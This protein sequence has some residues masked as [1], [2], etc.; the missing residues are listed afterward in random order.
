MNYRIQK[1]I[2]E[3]IEAVSEMMQHSAHKMETLH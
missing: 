2:V 1:Q 3:N